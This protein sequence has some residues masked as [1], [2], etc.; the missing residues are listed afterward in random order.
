MYKTWPKIINVLWFKSFSTDIY[1]ENYLTN[2]LLFCK[3]G[4]N[5][6][7]GEKTTQN[8]M[9]RLSLWPGDEL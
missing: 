3:K 7:M 4:K 5:K 6:Y 2:K 1:K 9:K 8:R